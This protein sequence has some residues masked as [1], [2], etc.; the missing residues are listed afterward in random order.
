[1]K[2]LIKYY[3]K[4]VLKNISAPLALKPEKIIFF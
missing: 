1:M 4:D 3:D 2:T